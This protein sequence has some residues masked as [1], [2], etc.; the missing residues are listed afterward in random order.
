MKINHVE[1]LK[2]IL[3]QLQRAEKQLKTSYKRCQK[4]GLTR[5]HNEEELIEFEAL[6]G[7]FAR[8]IDML[9]HKFFRALDSL[10]FV[11][12]GTLI[13]VVNRAEKRGIVDSALTIRTLKDIRNEI[14]HEYLVEKLNRLHQEVYESVPKLLDIIDHSVAY[15]KRYT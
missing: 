4:I 5:I 3:Q 12:G 14:A 2:A 1:N 15:A 13:D 11:E 9:V 7:R 6:T 8:L 10:E